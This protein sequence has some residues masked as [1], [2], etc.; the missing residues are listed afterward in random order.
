MILS[1][2]VA[3]A[4]NGVIGREGGLPWH[5]SADLKR[6]KRLTM[7][8][9]IVMGRKTWES[10]G[11]PLPGRTML[12]VSRQA[13]Y[14]ANGVQVV[15]SLAEAIDQAQQAGEETLFVIGGAE[16]YRQALPKA[17]R[18]YLTRVLAPID[19][20]THFPEIDLSVWNPIESQSH[21]AD[22]NNDHDYRF[23][24]FQQ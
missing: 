3:V 24:V 23:E 5:L 15:G 14:Q 11:R 18:L 17:N 8:H 21:I 19:G 1:L 12:V 2:I 7:G 16:I 10:I 20:D 22:A 13:D 9:T 6:F 4:E